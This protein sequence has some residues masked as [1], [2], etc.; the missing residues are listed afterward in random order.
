MKVH[1]LAVCVKIINFLLYV[2]NHQQE[3]VNSILCLLLNEKMLTACVKMNMT[4]HVL[5]VAFCYCL[6]NKFKL[7]CLLYVHS[8]YS[9][10]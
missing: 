10:V 1:F 9:K 7:I 6:I 4:N 5:P 2:H 3:S 8:L